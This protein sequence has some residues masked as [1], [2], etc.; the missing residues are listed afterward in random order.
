[1]GGR[2][3]GGRCRTSVRAFGVDGMISLTNHDFRRIV[4][5]EGDPW[6]LTGTLRR[7]SGA[8]SGGSTVLWDLFGRRTPVSEDLWP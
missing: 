2:V 1:M 5:D 4:G 8:V 6:S 3:F 7:P